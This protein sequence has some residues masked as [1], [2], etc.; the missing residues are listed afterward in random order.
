MDVPLDD[1]DRDGGDAVVDSSNRSSSNSKEGREAARLRQQLR[2]LLALPIRGRNRLGAKQRTK[3]AGT[4]RAKPQQGNKMKK[5]A[6]KG[7]KH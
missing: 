1:M 4:Q 3:V 7:K 5:R 6:K 2:G